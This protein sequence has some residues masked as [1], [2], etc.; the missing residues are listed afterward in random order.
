MKDSKTSELKNTDISGDGPR[1]PV[2]KGKLVTRILGKT[3]RVVTTFG[4]GG[5]ASIQWTPP[6][7][8][9]DGIILKA[10]EKGVTYFDTSNLYGPSQL[11]YGK[12][13][14]RLHLI[15]D[16]T[17][18]DQKLR[19][20]IFLAAKTHIR[21]AVALDGNLG[22]NSGSNGEWVKTAIDD[23]HR[24]LSQIFGDG[25]GNY[26]KGAYLDL[27]QIHSINTIEEVDAVFE[28]LENPDPSAEHIGALAG[29]LD[30]RDGTN[31]TGVNPRGEKLIRHIGITGH[32]SSPALMDAIQRDAQGI[33]DTLLVAINSND[34]LYLN[35]QHN[36]IPVA[37]AKGIGV[38]G[39][40]VFADAKYYGR[41][42]S[43]FS[44]DVEDVYMGVGSKELPSA[45]LVQYS[46]SVPG[47]DCV[48]I[49]IGNIS[50]SDDPSEDQLVGNIA[51][52]QLYEPLS[53]EKIREI[54][55]RTREVAGANTNYFQR[56]AVGL[57]PPALSSLCER[58]EPNTSTTSGSNWWPL[59]CFN[60][61][62]ACHGG[63]PFR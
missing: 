7:I 27:M 58:A 49:G 8:D 40:K 16:R 9:P 17:D 51:A 32:W 59:P 6:G 29:L 63:I 56:P 23:V 10:I 55:Q 31:R 30:L 47:V 61:S 19:E 50:V 2:R 54:E 18:Y 60:S 12:A 33:I 20:R 45:P 46:L 42:S 3:S 15:P 24:S 35:H 4:L 36:V 62:S 1:A 25:K 41:R 28:G 38:I 11:T 57:I 13:F 5:Q 22:P 21:R 48:I 52:A 14:R 34:K 37:D 53:P 26:P 44:N 39:M 43:S